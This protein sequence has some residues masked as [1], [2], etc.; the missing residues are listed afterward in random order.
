MR[1]SASDAIFRLALGLAGG[2]TSIL[3]AVQDLLADQRDGEQ[4]GES[5]QVGRLGRKQTAHSDSTAR[6]HETTAIHSPAHVS[7][8]QS[9]ARHFEQHG[10]GLQFVVFHGTRVQDTGRQCQCT[11]RV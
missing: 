5:P 7:V 8:R 1:Y 10:R 11:C 6:S 3:L 9:P 2:K 4:R